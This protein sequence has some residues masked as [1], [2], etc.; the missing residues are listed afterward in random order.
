[1]E[2]RNELVKI[3]EQYPEFKFNFHYRD[4][5]TDFLR[6]YQSQTNYNIS[7]TSISLYT[8]MYKGKKSY[9]F[10]LKNPTKAKLLEKIEEVKM[11]IDK[12]PEDPD[13]ID[14][15]DDL[16][17]S[18]EKE[19]INNIKK[20]SLDKKIDILE[21]LAKAVEPFDFKIYGTFICNYKTLYIINS[22]G[23]NK[24]EINSPIFLEVKAVSQKNEVTVLETYGGENFNTFDVERF[25]KDL[26]IKV[27]AATSEI[28]DVEPGEYEV[29]LAPRCIGD[30][31]LYLEGSISAQS[32]DT[33]QSFFEG[34]VGEKVFPENVTITDDP[35][36]PDLINFDY[37]HDG[38]IYKKLPIIEKGVFKNFM[39]DNYYGRKLK[40]KKNGAE[41]SGFV[42]E[43][44]NKTR[45][46]LIGSIK[47]GLYISSLHYMNFINQKETSLTG[48]TRD[49]TF[50]IENGRITKVVNNL[51]FTEKISDIIKGISE[52]ENQAYT[53]PY[54]SNYG[55]FGIYST[56]MP[57]VRVKGF[58]ISSSTRTV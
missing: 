50:L 31:L 27:E 36:H 9:S 16:T 8:T 14:L 1:M 47:K 24:R 3:Y 38:H 49:G 34:K 44:G 45:E 5:E 13:F 6:F 33:K 42:M 28:V 53:I 25:T 35:E 2:F 37:N 54:S 46:E 30:Y 19:K 32:L 26:V 18:A 21:K 57:H 22:N 39:V 52:I 7:K 20:V 58:K 43:T 40:M 41:G 48:L 17:K 15:E 11:I 4:W 56:R 12:L 55:E 51:R 29:V 23:V 10:S